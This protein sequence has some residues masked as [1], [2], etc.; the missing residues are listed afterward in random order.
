M[1]IHHIVLLKF[2]K[3][4]A[5]AAVNRYQEELASLPVSNADIANWVSGPLP[6]PR[7]HNGDFDFGMACDLPDRAAMERY[8]AHPAHRRL[9]PFLADILDRQLAFDFE[10]ATPPSV[11]PFEIAD[12][13]DD[14]P[15]DGLREEHALALLSE[16][17]FAVGKISHRPNPFWAE[18][19]VV[20]HRRSAPNSVDLVIST[21][22]RVGASAPF[23]PSAP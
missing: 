13:A 20:A 4:A 1:A 9:G 6:E 19:F 17:G 12:D 5:P 21:P 16:R 15:V 10:I 14:V 8:M 18:G 11:V 3:D 2:R 7:F 22:T 23:E